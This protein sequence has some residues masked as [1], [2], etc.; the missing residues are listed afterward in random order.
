MQVMD[1]AAQALTAFLDRTAP[2]QGTVA[3]PLAAQAQLSCQERQSQRPFVSTPTWAQHSPEQLFRQ[4]VAFVSLAN[5]LNSMKAGTKTAQLLSTADEI[6]QIIFKRV[7]NNDD[8]AMA[9]C[10]EDLMHLVCGHCCTC[11]Y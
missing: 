7:A 8:S 5:F 2:T 6:F 9:A 1:E 11:F 10:L 4:A 3:S